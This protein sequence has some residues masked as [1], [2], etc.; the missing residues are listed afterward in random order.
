MSILIPKQKKKEKTRSQNPARNQTSDA[1]M[2]VSLLLSP[3]HKQQ[4]WN[5]KLQLEVYIFQK[6]SLQFSIP[7][8]PWRSL[9]LHT[10]ILMQS[11]LHH[12]YCTEF[13]SFAFYYIYTTS[14]NISYKR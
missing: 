13:F 7:C 3:L 4:K 8:W 11:Q 14:Q 12:R 10:H 6:C 9:I 5:D 1:H 2:T